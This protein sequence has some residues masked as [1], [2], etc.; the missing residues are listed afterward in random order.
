MTIPDA[1]NA[2]G[3]QLGL[4]FFDGSADAYA[5]LSQADQV[6]VSDALKAYIVA[7]SG[8][9]TADQVANARKNMASAAYDTGLADTS[10]DLGMFGSEVL[11][12]AGKITDAGGTILTRVLYL[13]AAAGLVAYLLPTFL[14]RYRRGK[15]ESPVPVKS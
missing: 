6:R 8:A 13:A 5:N 12:N 14:T 1:R 10:F 11:N 7:N 9:F 3:K 15:A 4:Y 2:V